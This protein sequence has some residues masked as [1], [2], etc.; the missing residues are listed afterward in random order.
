MKFVA[1][2]A[3]FAGSVGAAQAA[4]I[5][6]TASLSGNATNPVSAP[7]ANIVGPSVYGSLDSTAYNVLGG[8][9]LNNGIGAAAT[10]NIGG[11][12][13]L[14]AYNGF[15]FTMGTWTNTSPLASLV[16]GGGLCTQTQTYTISGAVDDG[17]GGKDATSF[18]GSF[19]LSG[20]CAGTAGNCTGNAQVA[21]S[22]S[23]TALGV[24]APPSVPEPSALALVS[25]ALLGLG[26]SRRGSKR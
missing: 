4:F 9:D 5:N 6:G 13:L 2:I 21:W 1:A 19:T 23:L 16:C 7:A 3:V 8:G 11:P 14:F 24:Q 26:L 25:L 12:G 18:L 17:V 10:F 20:S 22:S 15:T